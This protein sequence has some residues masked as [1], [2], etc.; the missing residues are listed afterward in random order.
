MG[1][2]HKID[3]GNFTL[4]YKDGDGKQRLIFVSLN[5]KDKIIIESPIRLN[6][7]CQVVLKAFINNRLPKNTCSI[8][9]FLYAQ[10]RSIDNQEFLVLKE[11]AT[12]TETVLSKIVVM[13]LQSILERFLARIDI[14]KSPPAFY[15]N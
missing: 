7:F 15:G 9:D 5:L 12:R 1:D 10:R 14:F 6:F 8:T 4:V 13:E 11:S 2:T 3:I